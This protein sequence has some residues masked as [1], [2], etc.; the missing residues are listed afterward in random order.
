M[1]AAFKDI[2]FASVVISNVKDKWGVIKSAVVADSPKTVAV[3]DT[4][5]NT[6]NCTVAVVIL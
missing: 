3:P 2:S 6:G 5:N 1:C 4:S